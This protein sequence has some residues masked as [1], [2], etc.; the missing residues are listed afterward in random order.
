MPVQDGP[1]SAPYVLP[2]RVEVPGTKTRPTRTVPVRDRQ[3]ARALG[4]RPVAR[5]A[6]PRP[7]KSIVTGTPW[8]E[9]RARSSFSTQ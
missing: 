4:M 1:R 5:P 3:E 8:S 9:K 7:T 2:G 6:Q